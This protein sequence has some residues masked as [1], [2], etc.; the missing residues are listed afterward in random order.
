MKTQLCTRLFGLL[1]AAALASKVT[2]ME[3]R[4]PLFMML[5]VSTPLTPMKALSAA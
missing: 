1:A 2:A 4:A 3:V 5:R